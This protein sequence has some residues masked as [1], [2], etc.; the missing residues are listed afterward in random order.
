LPE[1]SA[2]CSEPLAPPTLSADAAA[3]TAALFR[4]LADPHRVRIV[5][6]LASSP[7]PVR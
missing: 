2:A 3:A 1:L 5:N 6:L 7:S 4:A